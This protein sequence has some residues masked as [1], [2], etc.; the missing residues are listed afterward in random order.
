M[1]EY[2]TRELLLRHSLV[3]GCSEKL[4]CPHHDYP[5]VSAKD[6][7]LLF[8]PVGPFHHA[9]QCQMRQFFGRPVQGG[10]LQIT[11]PLWLGMS[12]RLLCLLN[13]SC[14]SVLFFIIVE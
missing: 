13:C 14:P 5:V 3:P 1:G 9:E 10:A 4:Q 2:E 11:L 7:L 6:Q 8:S 12:E